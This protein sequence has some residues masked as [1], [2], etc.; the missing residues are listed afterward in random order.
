MGSRKIAIVGAGPIGLEA[1]LQ[2]RQL[3]FEVAVYEAGAVGEHFRR[4]GPMRLFTPFAMNSTDSGRRRLCETGVDVPPDD[5]MLTAEEFRG[6]YLLPLS[7]LP[8]LEGSIAEKTRVTAIGREGLRKSQAIA[9]TGNH[10][11]EGRPFLLRV[12]SSAAGTRFERADIVLD[13]SGVY[14]NPSATGPGGLP[15]A[16]EELLGD[17]LEQHLPAIMGEARARFAGKRVLLIG[18]A[19]SAEN[20][21]VDLDALIRAGGEGARTRVAWVHRDRGGLFFAPVPDEELRR[22]PLL[23]DLHGRAQAIALEAAWLERYPGAVIASYRVLPSGAVLV[24]LRNAEGR[25]WTVEVDRVL[26]LVGYRPDTALYRELQIHLCYAS[27]GPMAL[28]TAVLSASL[29]DPGSGGGCLSQTPHGPETLKSPEP[30]FYI[31][32]AKSYGRNPNFLL[33]LG[34]RQIADLFAMIPGCEAFARE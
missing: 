34:H 10:T 13:A 26:A 14:D 32:G 25:E 3:G 17:R 22:L 21:L 28:A 20:A 15:A 12:D 2:A 1:A 6:R 27:E 8:E 11:R 16:G 33:A 4:Y 24:A 30:D 5:A 23:R 18:D 29:Q 19:R 7:R 31:L 9:A